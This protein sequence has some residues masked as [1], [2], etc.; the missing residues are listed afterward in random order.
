MDRRPAVSGDF[1]VRQKHTLGK[2]GHFSHS[3]WLEICAWTLQVP[4]GHEQ[5]AIARSKDRCLGD[6]LG[7]FLDC[8]RQKHK[9]QFDGGALKH[10]LHFF[11]HLTYFK[12]RKQCLFARL[13]EV[14][15]RAR[16]LLAIRKNAR[17][18][19][20]PG[21]RHQPMEGPRKAPSHVT[22]LAGPFPRFSP[23]LSLHQGTTKL[24]GGPRWHEAP[25]QSLTAS[26]LG[27]KQRRR[28]DE[29]VL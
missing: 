21:G 27:R 22:W 26:E 2:K 20:C 12:A 15:Q 25:S 19:D 3:V 4:P 10:N 9:V 24:A 23:S 8:F 1:F 29:V 11:F 5:M 6:H 13:W 17:P 18:A 28:T 7:L 16:W 14:Q